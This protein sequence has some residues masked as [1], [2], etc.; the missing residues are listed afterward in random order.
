MIFFFF[1]LQA[2][3]QSNA[4]PLLSADKSAAPI[5]DPVTT[6][7]ST[8]Y[9]AQSTRVAPI[10]NQQMIA[11]T[12]ADVLERAEELPTSSTTTITTVSS[13]EQSPT[14]LSSSSVSPED[15]S[16]P[17]AAQADVMMIMDVTFTDSQE[18]HALCNG[19]TLKVLRI[20]AI[21]LL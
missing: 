20:K 13:F 18:F 11:D 8:F 6:L 10:T 17:Q 21:Q 5:Y 2:K 15:S 12:Y 4:L 16:P 14:P 3:C 1:F 7:P 9:A 19:I